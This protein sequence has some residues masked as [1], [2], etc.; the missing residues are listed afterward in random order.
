M[1]LLVAG[2]GTGGHLF[3]GLAVAEALRER[4]PAAEVLFVGTRRGLEARVVPKAGLA[5]EFI[6]VGALKGQGPARAARTLFGLPRALAQA[7][8]IVARF[9]P[10]LVLGVGGYAS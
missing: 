8:R 10:D 5:V 2:G 1:R 9:R 3:P 6:E 7:A 4:Q